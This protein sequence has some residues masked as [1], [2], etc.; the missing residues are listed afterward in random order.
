MR[1]PCTP[2]TAFRTALLA[3]FLLASPPAAAQAEF[4]FGGYPAGAGDLTIPFPTKLPQLPD[5]DANKSYTI[6]D[7]KG[8]CY[9]CRLIQSL[10]IEAEAFTVA[11]AKVAGI[12]GAIGASGVGRA[13]RFGVGGVGASMRQMSPRM[14][15]IARRFAA[16]RGEKVDD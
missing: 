7:R 5:K 8:P 15:D 13:G 14:A 9:I 2:C 11:T 10:T 3:V 6:H 12:G 1:T 16:S 4:D